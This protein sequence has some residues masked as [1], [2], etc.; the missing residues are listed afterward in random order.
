ML[1]SPDT[2]E[3][4]VKWKPE[5]LEYIRQRYAVDGAA[6]TTIEKEITERTGR[7]TTGPAIR[8]VAKRHRWRRGGT[9]NA[10]KAEIRRLIEEGVPKAEL[11]QKYDVSAR[12]I[13]NIAPGCAADWIRRLKRARAHARKYPIIPNFAQSPI[14]SAGKSLFE[15]LRGDC[16]DPICRDP[17]TNE[18]RFCAEPKL[19]LKGPWYCAKHHKL[20]HQK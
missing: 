1:G 9:C 14:S 4:I 18:F 15:L 20:N 11:A 3:T 10:E 19:T 2:R 5:D 8:N 16:R 7:P 13:S 6:S 17:E 12:Q